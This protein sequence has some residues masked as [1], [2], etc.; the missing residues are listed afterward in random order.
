MIWDILLAS[1]ALAVGGILKGATGAGAPVLA[2]PILAIIFDVPHAVALM[3]VPNLFSNISQIR[4]Y[5]HERITPLFT[6]GFAGG[7]AF[8]AFV[9]TWMLATLRP[10]LLMLLVAFAV[11]SYIGFRLLKPDWGLPYPLAEKL[12]TPVGAIGGM[13]QGASG[14]SA[15][16][17]IT[18]LNAARLERGQFIITISIFFT[19]MSLVQIPFLWLW[20]V[21]TPQ[22]FG[23]GVLALI[24]LMGAMPLGAMVGRMVSPVV[25]D[26][27]ILALLGGI[28]IKL[29]ATAIP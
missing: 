20:G 11:L 23:L 3:V 24:P 10:E 25:F 7:G 28:S 1:F 15:P 12:A 26:R 9:G 17:S 22:L 14:L 6:W 13:L 21:L 2:I 5:R 19:A 27:I 4:Q 16:A 18:F 29:I 8:G